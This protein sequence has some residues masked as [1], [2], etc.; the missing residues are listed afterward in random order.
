MTAITR[1]SALAGLSASACTASPDPSAGEVYVL[2]TLYSRHAEVLAYDVADLRRLIETINADALVL[3][4]TPRE[5]RERR[6]HES[7]IEYV[8]AVF[9]YL[10]ASAKPAYAAEPDEPLFTE[11]TTPLGQAFANLP[12]D[13]S[14][15]LDQYESALFALLARHWTS[16]AA[17]NDAHTDQL[18]AA[19]VALTGQVV[20]AYAAGQSRWDEHTAARAM[21]AIGR[22]RGARVLVL[23][24]VDNAPR[25]R[26]HLKDAGAPL[27]CMPRWLAEN[28]R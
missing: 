1:R 24:G 6:V 20:P 2:S 22:H 19:K 16:A 17:V 4:V 13:I 11:I 15:A 26:A 28:F 21:D 9:P 27:V 8:G 10:A 7:K 3:D 12:A 5:L 25:V 23:T 18:M 14:A